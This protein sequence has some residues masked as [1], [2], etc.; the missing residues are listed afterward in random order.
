[1][2]AALNQGVAQRPM[3]IRQRL[4]EILHAGGKPAQVSRHRGSKYPF[5][6][7]CL[8]SGEA[9]DRNLARAQL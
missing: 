3:P 4:L 9:V 2:L 5:G 8:P 1:M 6:R 7:G